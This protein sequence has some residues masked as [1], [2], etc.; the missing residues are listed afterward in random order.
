MRAVRTK[1]FKLVRNFKPGFPLKVPYEFIDNV[2]KG[3]VEKYF[4]VPRPEYEL[5]DLK[6]DPN[7]FNNLYACP[8]YCEIRKSLEGKLDVFLRA[9]DDPILKGDIPCPSQKPLKWVWYNDG[10]RFLLKD[11]LPDKGA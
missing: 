2:G 4:A 8:D 10:G 6:R 3:N 9:T 11:F 5:Y 7:E 1:D